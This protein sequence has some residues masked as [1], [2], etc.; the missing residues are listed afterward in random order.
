MVVAT[1]QHVK[2]TMCIHLY[3]VYHVISCS[4]CGGVFKGACCVRRGSC[5]L[6]EKEASDEHVHVCTYKC[7]TDCVC[8]YV[9][10]CT[11]ACMYEYI[12]SCVY[13]CYLFEVSVMCTRQVHTCFCC[14]TQAEHDAF[15][16]WITVCCCCC[17]CCAVLVASSFC[18]ASRTAPFRYRAAS[19]LSRRSPCAGSARFA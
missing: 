16:F 14:F 8:M 9:H 7:S 12:C 5:P 19:P 13:A 17:C 2:Y 4:L 1:E 11:C 10:V 15:S 18:R 6:F 3:L